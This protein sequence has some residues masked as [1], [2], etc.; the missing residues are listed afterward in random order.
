VAERRADPRQHRLARESQPDGKA[1]QQDP[2]LDGSGSGD[3]SVE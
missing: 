2:P 1:S 3:R